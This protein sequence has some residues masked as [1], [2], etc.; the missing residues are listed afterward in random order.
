VINHNTGD[1]CVLFLKELVMPDGQRRP[2]SMWLS[3]E[4]PE[5]SMACARR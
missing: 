5:R 4:Y 1:D 3:G 2:H